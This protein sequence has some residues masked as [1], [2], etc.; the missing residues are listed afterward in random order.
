V[1]C[2]LKVLFQILDYYPLTSNIDCLTGSALDAAYLSF[3]YFALA[4]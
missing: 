2:E 1:E 4:W 3:S